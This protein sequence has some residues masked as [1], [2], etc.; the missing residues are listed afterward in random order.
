[1]AP[2][3]LGLVVQ[4][5]SLVGQAVLALMLLLTRQEQAHQLL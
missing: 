3:H 1:M 5:V 2:A 4:S